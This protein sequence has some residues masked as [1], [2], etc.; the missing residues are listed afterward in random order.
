[1]W[2]SLSMKSNKPEVQNVIIIGY[3]GNCIDIQETLEDINISP[4]PV[5]YKFVGFLD[6]NPNS[7]ALGP[8]AS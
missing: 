2:K 5:K 1:M 8:L 4:S 3:G 7:P 6:D